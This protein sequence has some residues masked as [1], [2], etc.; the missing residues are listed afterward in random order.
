MVYKV[1]AAGVVSVLLMC[2]P[3]TA[4]EEKVVRASESAS[5]AEWLSQLWNDL[6]AWLDGMAADGGC[7]IDP[8]GV[9]SQVGAP[10]PPESEDDGGCW[11]D[12]GGSANC[13]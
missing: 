8:G 6:G 11:I 9:C 2:V 12:P 3:V 1:L 10:A 4:L 5:A 13:G 7:W